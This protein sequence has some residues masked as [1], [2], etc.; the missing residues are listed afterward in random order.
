ML[1]SVLFN[2]LWHRL[3]LLLLVGVMTGCGR[4]TP[5]AASQSEDNPNNPYAQF[6]QAV[7][8]VEPLID[9][10]L[11][12]LTASRLQQEAPVVT[13]SITLLEDTPLAI[14]GNVTMVSAP[15]MQAFNEQM[16]QRLI[17]AGYSGLLDINVL[18]AG[19][20]IQ[21][22]CQDP[23]VNFLSV[24][25]AMSEAEI[26]VCQAKGR[27][28]LGLTIGKD[29]LLLVVNRDNDFVRG[30]DLE[31]LKAVLT[32]NTW[33]EIDMSWPNTAIERGMIGPNSSTVAL[34]TQTLFPADG[35]SLL[36]TANTTF[37]DY[38]EPMVQTLS[39]VPNG[40]A[41]INQSSYER[42]TATF[43]VIPINGISASL[44]TVESNAYPL[45]QSLLLYVDQKQ[46]ESGTPTKAV[47]NFYL[48][49]M[50]DVMS[51]V[52]LLPLNQAQLDQTK[53]QWLK[54][55]TTSN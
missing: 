31:K 25:R 37:Y 6:R 19:S 45:I 4:L 40:L 23:S 43:R 2:S 1:Y 13:S 16:Y 42:F 52:G 5:P 24:N 21:Q 7:N 10:N 47:A 46:L 12:S 48:T 9:P 50:T 38:P 51:E 14:Q 8:D 33:S 20:A 55:T 29:P 26:Q 41:F 11:E 34:L 15:T 18:R 22:F 27:Q 44:D 32:K 53:R 30:I 3:G 36:K 17:Q 49:E 35:T 39:T 54:A 28:P